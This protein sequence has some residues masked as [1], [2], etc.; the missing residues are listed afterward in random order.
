MKI[1]F[2][3]QKFQKKKEKDKIKLLEY[4]KVRRE[5]IIRFIN[6]KNMKQ[7]YFLNQF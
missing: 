1:L 5:I 3:I 6:K 7:F 2:L 4:L